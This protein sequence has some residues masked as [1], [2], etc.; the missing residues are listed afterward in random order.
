MADTDYWEALNKV[1]QI[2]AGADSELAN[3]I[4]IYS[5]KLNSEQLATIHDV[6]QRNCILK[7][8]SGLNKTG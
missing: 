4:T 6:Y 7:N 3:L 8:I 1:S 2:E 5:D